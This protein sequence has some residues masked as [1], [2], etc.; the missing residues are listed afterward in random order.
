M[1]LEGARKKGIPRNPE[2]TTHFLSNYIT[3]ISEPWVDSTSTVSKV[4]SSLLRTRMIPSCSTKA[5]K[6]EETILQWKESLAPR[7][8]SD[9]QQT[10][11]DWLSVALGIYFSKA[12]L[13]H[14]IAEWLKIQ[15]F[16]RDQGSM[17]KFIY[18]PMAP[19]STC[20][21][22]S[23]VPMSNVFVWPGA[24]HSNPSIS[25][26]P[27][28]MASVRPVPSMLKSLARIGKPAK[29]R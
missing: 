21:M 12:N 14:K 22:Q 28:A 9:W 6:I 5:L 24:L 10:N 2:N 11:K 23:H 26:T 18:G 19:I 7:T 3:V 25:T 16:V 17:V 1:D 29:G 15:T 8:S 27:I 4:D 20:T 13:W